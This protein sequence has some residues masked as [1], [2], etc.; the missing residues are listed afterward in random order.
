[1][2]ASIGLLKNCVLI[3]GDWTDNTTSTFF[4]NYLS[5]SNPF[6]AHEINT[7]SWRLWLNSEIYKSTDFSWSMGINFSN[8]KNKLILSEGNQNTSPTGGLAIV[9]TED[10]DQSYNKVLLGG[11][12]QGIRFKKLSLEMNGSVCF[13]RDALNASVYQVPGRQPIINEF[14]NYQYF[15][16]NYMALGY[17]LGNVS[18]YVK[19]SSLY[20]VGRNLISTT[21][22]QLYT[23]IPK[24]VGLSLKVEL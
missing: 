13:N 10:D 4:P 15:A 24:Y 19:N 12:Q 23:N 20:L 1:M 22:N 7:K 16:I 3:N 2:S 14:K 9:T 21:E 17:S 11:I 8:Q 5:S 6:S 18:K